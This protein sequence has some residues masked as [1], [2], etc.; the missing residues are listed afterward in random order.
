MSFGSKIIQLRDEEN[1]SRKELSEKL[2]IAY[3]TL[4]KYETDARFPDR[5]TLTII[6]DNFNVSVDFLLGRTKLREMSAETLLEQ[7]LDADGLSSDELA[8]V[9]NMID[10]IKQ[11]KNR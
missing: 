4:S 10:L 6:A 2:G 3:Q 9:Q 5:D 7:A 11:I 8:A 1:L